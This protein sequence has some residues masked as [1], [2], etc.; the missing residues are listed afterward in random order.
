M[1]TTNQI[2]SNLGMAHMTAN[3]KTFSNINTAKPEVKTLELLGNYTVPTST[4]SPYAIPA[5]NFAMQ[6]TTSVMTTPATPIVPIEPASLPTFVKTDAH[7]GTI[8]HIEPVRDHFI[9]AYINL[10]ALREFAVK[11]AGNGKSLLERVENYLKDQ[12]DNPD[13]K[14]AYEALL[15]ELGITLGTSAG[16]SSAEKLTT[17]F[18]STKLPKLGDQQEVTIEALGKSEKIN[19]THNTH[20]ALFHVG[21]VVTSDIRTMEALRHVLVKLRS[22]H[23]AKLEQQQ[24]KL[25]VLQNKINQ[26]IATFDALEAERSE[27]RNDYAVAQRLLAEHWQAIEAKFAE[28]QRIL[29]NNVGLYYVRVRETPLSQTLPDP[30]DLRFNSPGDLVPGCAGGVATLVEELHPFMET[31]LDIPAADWAQLSKLSQFLPGRIPLEQMVHRRKQVMSVKQSTSNYSHVFH[32]TLNALLS[33]HPMMM[34]SIMMQP[35]VFTSLRNMQQ[36]GH[37]ILALEDLI[38]SPIAAL[39]TPANQLHQQLNSAAS[40]L[41]ERL[42]VIKPSIRM[43]WANL[44]DD[45]RLD[46]E[47]PAKWPELDKA[48]AEDFNNLRT[49]IELIHWW[50]NQLDSDASGNSRTTL[51]NFIRACLL[52]AANDDPQQLLQGQ[53]QILPRRFVPG[54]LLRLNLNREPIPGNLLNLLNEKQQ[55]VATVRV[56]DHDDNGTLASIASLIGPEVKLTMAMQVVGQRK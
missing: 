41:L 47:T 21:K 39:R 46:V 33:N 30:L 45:N 36:Q 26:E 16:E 44:A 14:S 51:R 34:Q 15:K 3:T 48:E 49:I 1:A 52:L 53:L 22:I 43:T 12:L 18:F 32:P 6:P 56:E 37:K 11:P 4:I 10:E 40:C 35:F 8:R 31:V 5:Y 9:N 17:R 25:A 7:F 38:A 13:S 19:F 42:Q 55:V 29:E 54:E 50:F 24:I 2:F 23:Q 28:R 20:S 27:A